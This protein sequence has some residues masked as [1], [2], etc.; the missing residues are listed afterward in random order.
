MFENRELRKIF[1]P[2]KDE[3]TGDRRKWRNEK[4]RS[5]YSSP[6]VIRMFKSRR[7]RWTEHVTRM[8]R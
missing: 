1:V 4:L 8:G 3:V 6:N 5:L 7:I 2:K